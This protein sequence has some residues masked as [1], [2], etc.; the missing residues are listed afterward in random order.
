MNSPPRTARKNPVAVGVAAV[1]LIAAVIAAFW[2]P[3]YARST[4]KLGAFAFFYWYQLLLVPAVAIVS[5][6]AYLLVRPSP[7]RATASDASAQPGGPPAPA[8]EEG[9]EAAL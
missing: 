1:L 5:W 8:A 4:P 6:L 3:L 9:P 2:V 7:R